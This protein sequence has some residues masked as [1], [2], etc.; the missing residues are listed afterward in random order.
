MTGEI[1]TPWWHPIETGGTLDCMQ[2]PYN[3]GT[4]W[5][6]LFEKECDHYDDAIQMWRGTREDLRY[7]HHLGEM[8]RNVITNVYSGRGLPEDVADLLHTWDEQFRGE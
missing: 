5:R 8:M 1:D 2:C 7:A 4:N 6:T 3:S